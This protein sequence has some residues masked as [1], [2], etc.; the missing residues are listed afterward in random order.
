M[1]YFDEDDLLTVRN[2][3]SNETQKCL[4]NVAVAMC[5]NGKN[6]ILACLPDGTIITL[7][8]ENSHF[9]VHGAGLN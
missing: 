1:N 8:W 3:E 4:R 2:I 6:E 5:K 7:Y 9:V